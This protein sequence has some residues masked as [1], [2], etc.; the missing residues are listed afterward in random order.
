M[1]PSGF[2]GYPTLIGIIFLRYM[3]AMIDSLPRILRFIFWEYCFLYLKLVPS[4]R[5]KEKYLLIPSQIEI[6]G[7]YFINGNTPH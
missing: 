3:L 1:G 5:F 6:C 2:P 7:G 4:H